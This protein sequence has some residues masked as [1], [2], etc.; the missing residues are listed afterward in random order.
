MKRTKNWAEH[1]KQLSQ[2]HITFVEPGEKNR[3]GLEGNLNSFPVLSR[4]DLKRAKKMLGVIL[5]Q[6]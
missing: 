4:A 3:L 5:K 6:E 1:K 2:T